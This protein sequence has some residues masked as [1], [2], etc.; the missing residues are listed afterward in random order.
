MSPSPSRFSSISRVSSISNFRTSLKGGDIYG[1][2]A[3]NVRKVFMWAELQTVTHL[4]FSKASQKVSTV[5]GGPLLGS[6]TTMVTNGLMC[7][8]TTEGKIVVHDFKQSLV[9]ICESN[10]SGLWPP[11]CLPF[12][13]LIDQ[14]QHYL[15]LSQPLH[16]PMTTLSLL[17]GTV[18]DIYN[19]ST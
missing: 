14:Q 13:F 3:H 19:F 16:C 7:V 12:L 6:P 15:D 11:S 10:I 17:Q 4:I 8:G 1:D 18:Q 2:E 5:L 9:C